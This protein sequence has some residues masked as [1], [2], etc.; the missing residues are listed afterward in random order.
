[1]I[2][3]IQEA[4]LAIGKSHRIVIEVEPEFKEQIYA[5]LKERGLTLKGWF[6]E[7]VTAELV[8]S[9]DNAGEKRS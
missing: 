6:T 9:D 5:A 2:K 3:V 4:A 7:K 8:P 1:M